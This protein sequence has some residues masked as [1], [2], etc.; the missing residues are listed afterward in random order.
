MRALVSALVAVVVALGVASPAHAVSL[1]ATLVSETQEAKNDVFSF[2]ATQNELLASYVQKYGSRFSAAES[3]ALTD[4]QAAA[5]RSLRNLQQATA[6]TDRLAQAGAPKARVH[7][8]ATAA[9]RSY[10]RAVAAAEATSASLEPVLR[11]RLSLGEAF[12]AY[13]DYSGALS[14]FEDIGIQLDAIAKRTK[15]RR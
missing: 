12:S 2:R 11:N 15:P 6:R 4:A 8:A 9:Q 10:E 5:D 3:Q 7:K 14:D 13:R 1:A